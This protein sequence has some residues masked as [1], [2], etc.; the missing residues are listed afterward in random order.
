[1][2]A[3][4]FTRFIATAAALL[5][6]AAL[7]AAKRPSADG[8]FAKSN[9]VAWC[10]VPFD[11]KH[12]GPVERAEMLNRL[13]ITKLAYDWRERHV[14]TFDQEIDALRAHGI[15]LQAFWLT[16]GPNPAS[17]KNVGIVLDLLRRRHVKTQIW[18]LF[19]PPRDFDRSS[20][21]Q[22]IEIA[23]NAVRY[24]AEKAAQIGCSVGLYN[25]GG[26]FGEPENELAIL[27]RLKMRNVGIVYNFNHAEQQI[28]RFPEFFPK[29]EPHL[30]ALNLSGLDK[31][32]RKVVAIGAGDSELEMINIIYKSRYRGPI[33][34]INEN[35]DPDAEVGL[36]KNMQGL[37][38]ILSKL[39]DQRA[40]KT[41]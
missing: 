39:G 37:E 1:M 34:I 38:T 32:R 25:H 13:G 5:L 21:I 18:Y 23:A 24:I 16:S 3:N 15:A 40:L 17:E 4:K 10:V 8:V 41:Y 33:G 29:V 26:W 6:L 11:S 35:T 7:Y 36:R 9:L 14:P 28:E 20:Q 2:S 19:I 30:I 27:D 22:K 12:R 31:K